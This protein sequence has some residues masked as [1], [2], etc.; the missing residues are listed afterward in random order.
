METTE[1]QAA[2]SP[3]PHFCVH[4]QRAGGKAALRREAVTPME[5]ASEKFLIAA[6]ASQAG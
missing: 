2:M 3:M 6:L 5:D 4:F 1:G